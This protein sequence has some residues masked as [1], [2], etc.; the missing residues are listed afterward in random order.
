MSAISDYFRT[1]L[2]IDDRVDSDYRPLEPLQNRQTQSA[3]AEPASGLVP[4]SEEDET[5]V[6]PAALVRA[7]LE[8]GVVCSVLEANEESEDASGLEERVLQGASSADLLI[9]D[10]LLYGDFSTTVQ[11]IDALANRYPER[12]AVVVVFTGAHSLRDVAQRLI[13]DVQFQPVDDYIVRRSN[14]V[15]LVFGKPGVRLTGDEYL[16]QA[17]DF[18]ELPRMIREDLEL[19]YR[20]LMP[21]FAFRGINALRESAPRVLATFDQELDVGALIHRALLPDPDE[22]ATQFIR[23]LCSDMELA[24]LDADVSSIWDVDASSEVLAQAAESGE[25]TP[26][27]DRLRNSPNVADDPEALDGDRLLKRAVADGLARIGLSDSAISK[28]VGDLEAAMAD[29]VT[30]SENLAILMDSSGFGNRPPRLELGVVVRDEQDS[31]WLCIQPLCDSVRLTGERAFPMMPIRKRPP[32][33]TAMIRSP[34]GEALPVALDRR[35]YML[36][37]VEFAPS[38][39]VVRAEPD[40]SAWRFTDVEKQNYLAFAR[41]RPEFAAQAVQDLTSTV[42]RVAADSSEWRRRGAAS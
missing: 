27:L 23:L 13:D 15:V 9:L 20:G 22:A 8:S 36:R 2:L 6:S 17:T 37:L 41:L 3:D 16:R 28:A 40:G 18:S 24:L 21:E 32:K 14:T 35:P 25:A 31:Y 42:A 10:W 30:S 5:A 11:A 33:P 34:E 38:D 29:S 26:L 7:F 12:I 4:P 39:G 19:V 1:A